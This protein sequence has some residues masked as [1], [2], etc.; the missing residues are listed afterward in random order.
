MRSERCRRA[1]QV[2]AGLILT[3]CVG[4]SCISGCRNPVTI[5]ANVSSP[6]GVWLAELITDDVSWLTDKKGDRAFLVLVRKPQDARDTVSQMVLQGV[7]Q[8]APS[9][10][11]VS[12]DALDVHVPPSV[13][14]TGKGKVAGVTV[15]VR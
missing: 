11:W 5:E 15:T 2:M 12:D 13:E 3:V 7:G 1:F 14:V 4:I 9:L 6:S 8:A 10:K